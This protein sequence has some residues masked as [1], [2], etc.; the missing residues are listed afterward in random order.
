MTPCPSLR[1]DSI[2]GGR[3]RW[4][5]RALALATDIYLIARSLTGTAFARPCGGSDDLCRSRSSKCRAAPQCSTGNSSG[6]DTERGLHCRCVRPAAR[7][8]A[9]PS[10]AR[11][12]LF[13]AGA[14][15]PAARRTATSSAHAAGSP[16]R[17]PVP[18]QLLPRGLG[19]LPAAP[20]TGA[21]AGWRLRGGHRLRSKARRH[22]V[23]P[24]A[25]SPV[26]RTTRSWSTP[27]AATRGWQMTTPAA[28]RWPRCWPGD[29]QIAP[30]LSFRF[31]FAP[32]TIGSVAWLATHRREL[33]RVRAGLVIGLLGDAGPLTY[34]RSRRGAAE[35]DLVA[36]QVVRELD[37]QRRCWSFRLMATTSGSSAPR[38][39]TCPSAGS[40]G[41]PTARIR[42]TTRPRMPRACCAKTRSRNRSRR[43]PGCS[44]ASMPTVVFAALSRTASRAWAAA[45]CSERLAARISDEFEHA[46]LW[47]LNMADG[48]HGLVDTQAASGLPPATLQAAASALLQAGLLER[49]D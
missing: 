1:L 38:A 24:N 48:E 47:L 49:A 22:H 29:G 44:P 17:H 42:N 15:A 31:V 41:R 39:S 35:I 13:N 25:A 46:M 40:R 5:R 18:N 4:Q 34:K 26:P 8:R 28:S 30:N 21:L 20:R 33:E 27:I 45:A 9:R 32:G 12:R 16:G 10:T 6:V 11:R 19:L 14:Q 3:L 37:P 7:R 43:S 36:A 23:S 2:D